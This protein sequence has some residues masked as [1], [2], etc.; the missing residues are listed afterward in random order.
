MKQEYKIAKGWAIFIWIFAPG[1]IALFGFMGISPYLDDDIDLTLVLILTPF[2]IGLILLMVLGLVDTVKSRLIIEKDKIISISVFKTKR[3]DFSDI[4]G[5]KRDQNYLYFIPKSTDLK[6]IKVSSY[7]GKFKELIIWSESQ[8]NNLDIEEIAK[9]TADIMENEEYGRNIDEREYRFR[10]AKRLTKILNITSLIIGLSTL[11]YPHFYK[12][13]ILVC[14][15]LPLIGLIA[16]K[17]SN[18]LIKIDGKPNSTHPKIFLTFLIPSCALAMRAILDFSIFEYKNFWLPAFLLLGVY[19]FIIFKESKEQFDLS[20]G[21]TYL[22]IFGVLIFGALYIYGLLITTNVTFD[23]SQPQVY[24][25]KI[26]DKRISTG[27]STTYYFELDQWGP[28]TEIEDVSVSR[29][30]YDSKIIG[31]SAIVYFNNGLYKIPYYIVIK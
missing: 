2:S 21:I 7:C 1:L 19:G 20:K 18:G 10:Q 25:A 24:K 4:Q 23:N 9:E 16:L 26:L 15:I 17:T 30:I 13:Q 14:T 29:D 8:F 12:I 3:L 22:S 28:Q 5:F 6:K 11:F 27:E 31:D